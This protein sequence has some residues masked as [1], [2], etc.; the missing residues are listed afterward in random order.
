MANLYKKIFTKTDSKTGQKKTTESKKWYARYTDINGVERRIALSSD[1]K[2]AQRK[3]DELV[4][5]VDQ[6]RDNDPIIEAAKRSPQEHLDD[7]KKSL[8]AKN[9]TT[10]YIEQTYNRVLFYVETMKIKKVN[11]ITPTS[12]ES[13]VALLRENYKYSLQTCNHYVRVIKTFCGWLLKNNRIARHPILSVSR[14]NVETDKRHARRA[15]E[16]EEFQ[17]L[18]SAAEVGKE[19]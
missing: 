4:L 12:V 7:F 3:L 16:M 17:R 8:K 10:R 15:L 11:G 14:F 13:F 9:N 18:V 19:I 2:I 6:G 5:A 1:K